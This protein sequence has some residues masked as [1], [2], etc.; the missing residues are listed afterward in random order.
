MPWAWRGRD[1]ALKRARLLLAG[2]LAPGG[3]GEK[4]GRLGWSREGGAQPV[5]ALAIWAAHRQARSMRSRLVRP[6]RVS[7]A[8]ACRTG[9]GM[10]RSRSGPATAGARSRSAWPSRPGRRRPAPP[11]A[12]HYSPPSRGRLRRPAALPSRMR[13]STRA[14]W[15]CR[16]SSPAICPGITPRAVSVR[17]AVIR[18][19]STSVKVSWAPGCGRSL[20]RMSRDPSGRLVTVTGPGGAGKTRLAGEVAGRVAGR[21]ADG[22]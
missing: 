11:P 17:N 1:D 2:R 21:S 7:W 3:G 16:N 15:R 12:R 19:P 18:C 6:E 4:R 10:R 8:A 9:S 14:C 13:S 5:E 20:R 22:V